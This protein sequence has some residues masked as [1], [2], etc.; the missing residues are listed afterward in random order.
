MAGRLF[1]P[2][3]IPCLLQLTRPTVLIVSK[4]LPLRFQCEPLLVV[5]SRKLF[6]WGS[7]F[8]GKLAL[9]RENTSPLKV[10]VACAIGTLPDYQR[11]GLAG[12]VWRTAEQSLAREVDAVLI[13]TGE[14]G[15]GYL[16]YRAMG[17]L[18]LLY[19]RPLRL[20][21]TRWIAPTAESGADDAIYGIADLFGATQ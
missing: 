4:S 10:A 13:Y 3:V 15:K 12:K 21:V 8:C 14:G 5:M 11:Q 20:M 2:V 9:G 18:P 16:F 1:W 19:P 6:P 7:F 17:Y